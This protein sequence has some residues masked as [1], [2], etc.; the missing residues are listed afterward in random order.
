MNIN[1][2]NLKEQKE[3]NTGDRE[4]SRRR[5]IKLGLVAAAASIVPYN[6]FAAAKELLNDERRICIYNLHTKEEVDAV[7]WKDGEYVPE[8]LKELNYIFRDHYNGSERAMKKDLFNAL[9]AIQRKLQCNE[10][11]HL[12]SGYRSRRTN[13]MLRKQN[14]GVSRRSLH[15]RGMAAD[16]RL[17]GI[18]LKALRKAAYDLQMGGVGYYPRSNFVHLDV[19]QVRFWRG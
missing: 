13:D 3:M 1:G 10:P 9:H 15:I 19:G 17:P 5:L 12:I 14:K 4:I 8:A 6:S 7:F 16:L 2:G 18:K 11:F